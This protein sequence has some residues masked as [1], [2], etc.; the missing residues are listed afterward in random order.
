[1]T[2]KEINEI[3]QRICEVGC[4]LFLKSYI[5]G[6][7]GNISVRIAKDRFLITPSK[8]NKGFLK[9]EDIVEIDQNGKEVYKKGPKASSEK[10]VHLQFYKHLPGINS[11]IHAHPPAAT[12]YSFAAK[13]IECTYSPETMVFLGNHIPLVPYDTP[14]TMA[15]P[16]RF[17]PFLNFRTRAYLMQNH[18]VVTCAEDLEMAYNNMETLELYART[19][20]YAKVLGGAKPISMKKIAHLK[21]TFQ[22]D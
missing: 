5:S 11:V 13:D 8:V 1:M 12:A 7:G 3:K 9:P 16:A 15:L 22:L 4:R 2:K 6:T 18:G 20:M 17:T 21:S 10:P 14:S 19:L